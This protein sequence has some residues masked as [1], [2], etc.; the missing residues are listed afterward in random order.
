[1]SAGIAYN[2][3]DGTVTVDAFLRIHEI[4]EH[5]ELIQIQFVAHCIIIEV[6]AFG[7]THDGSRP[8]GLEHLIKVTIPVQGIDQRHLARLEVRKFAF[9]VFGDS[10]R[11]VERTVATVQDLQVELLGRCNVITDVQSGHK[12]AHILDHV[13][14]LVDVNRIQV[15]LETAVSGALFTG[16]ERELVVQLYTDTGIVNRSRYV[17]DHSS[18]L[19]RTVQTLAI[20]I[21]E[22]AVE[23]ALGFDTKLAH[24]EYSFVET[25]AEV[26]VETT[27]HIEIQ[28]ELIR[29]LLHVGQLFIQRFIFKKHLFLFRLLGIDSLYAARKEQHGH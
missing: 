12:I 8:A 16:K 21:G 2:P 26:G 14:V 6:L 17:V 13:A 11:L 1:M 18:S 4:D 22:P 9:R 10:I 24:L 19:V 27:L 29:L 3:G 25:V 7:F 15:E 28:I 23:V 20:T 5:I